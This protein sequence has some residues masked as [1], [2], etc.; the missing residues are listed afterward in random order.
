MVCAVS[1]LVPCDGL[2]YRLSPTLIMASALKEPVGSFL[3]AYTI[4]SLLSSSAPWPL[5]LYPWLLLH[6]P[7]FFTA[8]VSPCG[9]ALGYTP[10]VR[11]NQDLE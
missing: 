4:C 5:T 6:N 3:C 8:A 9:T 7:D 2:P 11:I 1:A 10:L